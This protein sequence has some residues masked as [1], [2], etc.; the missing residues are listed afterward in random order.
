MLLHKVEGFRGYATLL[1][2][3]PAEV[4]AL[5]RDKG[6]RESWGLRGLACVQE[7]R[8]RWP[9]I[10]QAWLRVLEGVLKSKAEIPH[11]NMEPGLV[12]KGLHLVENERVVSA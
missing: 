11:G 8:Y 1:R 7:P 9:V 2:E 4:D 12:N 6:L 3:N 5:Y 10:G